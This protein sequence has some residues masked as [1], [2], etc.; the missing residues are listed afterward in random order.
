MNALSVRRPNLLFINCHDLGRHLGCYG[1]PTLDTPALDSLAADGVRFAASFTTAPQC[2]PSRAALFTGR[3]PHC[4]GVMGLVHDYFRWDLLPGEKHLA[5]LLAEAGYRTALAGHQHETRRPREQGWQQ[6]LDVGEEEVTAAASGLLA[7]WTSSS[8]PFYL[9]VGYIRP[10]RLDTPSGFRSGP[11][12]ARGVTVPP[13]LL[14]EPSARED[15]AAFQADIAALDREVG[16]L[17][18]ALDDLGL[19]ANTWVVFTSD[20]GIPYPRAKCSL[21]DPGLETALLFRWPEGFQ[22]GQVIP[23]LFSNIDFLPTLCESLGLP[24][25]SSCQG[26]SHAPLLRGDASFVPRTELFGEMTYHNYYDPRRCVRTATHKL[27]VNFSASPS[28]MDP[29]QQWRPKTVSLRPADPTREFHEPI[30]LYDLAADPLEWHNRARDPAL[31]EVRRDLEARLRRWMMETADP[32]LS[33]PVPSPMH[34]IALSVL[35]GGEIPA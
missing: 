31:A 3:Y 7:Q 5:R 4:N 30:E 9:Q 33:G 12:G 16:R 19:R 13:Y 17:L 14:D 6:I 10:H 32:L 26:L 2:S 27:I 11:D 20:H 34:E 29:S 15:L 22:P 25:P 28:F 18:Q 24:I 35:Q 1:V 23:H 8:D 21:Y